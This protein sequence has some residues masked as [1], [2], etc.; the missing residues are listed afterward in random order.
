MNKFAKPSAFYFYVGG[1]LWLYTSNSASSDDSDSYTDECVVNPEDCRA[2]HARLDR[3]CHR[4]LLN[5]SYGSEGNLDS[6]SGDA[7]ELVH[8]NILARH[9]DRTPATT[10]RI[11]SPLFYQCGLVTGDQDWEDLRDFPKPS[12]LPASARIRNSRLELFPGTNFKRCGIGMLTN[13]G[14]QQHHALGSLMQYKY[15]D[16]IGDPSVIAKNIFVQS[17]DYSRTIHSAA[18]FL[19]GFLPDNPKIR[20]STVIHVSAGSLLQSPPTGIAVSYGYCRNYVQLWREDMEATKYFS[21]EKRV[22]H[23][24]MEKLCDM[25]NI[26]RRNEPIVTELF[27][28]I[29]TRGCHSDQL[30]CN[31]QGECVDHAF[32]S[33]LFAFADWTWNHRYPRNSSILGVIPFLKHSVL[34]IMNNAINHVPPSSKFVFSFSHDATLVRV[35]S[36]LG[37]PLKGWMPYASR[38]VFE[39]WKKI[40]T[41]QEYYVRVLFNGTPITNKIP[42]L[43]AYQRT[44]V[45]SRLNL[46]QYSALKDCLTTG[47]YRAVQSYHTVCGT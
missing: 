1:L 9:G 22:W 43:Q 36:S 4:S 35:L 11:G 30:P 33:Q 37:I 5:T 15:A 39:L 28:H 16:F 19:L 8:V 17:T 14:Y 25:F 41:E 38:I 32:A 7:F 10:H 3:Y 27:D 12:P 40:D 24:L 2:F 20:Q 42:L 21:V 18:S 47:K 44:Q 23:P 13:T 46:V 26:Q 31:R 29:L 6:V 45:E 34:E